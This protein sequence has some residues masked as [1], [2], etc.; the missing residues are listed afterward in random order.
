MNGLPDPRGRLKRDMVNLYSKYIMGTKPT[1]DV[2]RLG[3][4][5]SG[6]QAVDWGEPE[7]IE[8]EDEE[9]TPAQVVSAEDE[10]ED[11]V[12]AQAAE[13]DEDALEEEGAA[14]AGLS[15]VKKPEEKKKKTYDEMI[16]EELEFA[17][18]K[19]LEPKKLSIADILGAGNIRKSAALIRETE[20]ENEERQM[21]ARELAL[22]ILGRRSTAEKEQRSAEALAKY[23]NDVIAAR[24]AAANRGPTEPA[25]I[26]IDKDRAKRMYPDL[27]E[28]QAYAKYVKEVINKP[29]P[30]ARPPSEPL[31]IR[32]GMIAQMRDTGVPRKPTPGELKALEY[33]EQRQKRGGILDSL[34]ERYVVNPPAE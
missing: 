32:M 16:L 33:Y 27:P 6:Q 13:E 34:I 12:A 24:L 25:Q 23:R 14:M 11:Q 26:R 30:A 7:P 20:R 9:Q 21:K 31:D 18:A 2:R 19:L 1:A 8:D 28:D 10:S 22:E 15:D 5:V 4:T 29:R 17:K 3:A